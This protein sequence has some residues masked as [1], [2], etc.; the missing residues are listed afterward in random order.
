MRFWGHGAVRR[1]GESLLV[2][3]G[4]VP[5]RAY[6]T[7]HVLPSSEVIA[8]TEAVQ[9]HLAGLAAVPSRRLHITGPGVGFADELPL[10]QVRDLVDHAR[11]RL[12]AL[13]AFPCAIGAAVVGTGGV[14]FPATANEFSDLRAAL[15]EAMR[16]VGI[17]PPGSDE[18]VYAPHVS[19]A[20]ATG[21]ASRSEAAS[22]LSAADELPRPTLAVHAVSLLAL[23][24]VPPGY[25]W[26][27]CA[28][29][30]LDDR[31]G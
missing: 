20:Y 3:P 30:L 17:D 19:V 22:R 12:A 15:R 14:Y 11:V 28:T 6:L 18:E 5:G 9:E 4:W 1:D 26:T 23:R 7:W 10:E 13:P 27:E 24:M 29:V 21:P 16:S 31:A 2:R 25:D 8:Y